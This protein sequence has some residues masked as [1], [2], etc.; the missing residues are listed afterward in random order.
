[1]PTVD[2]DYTLTPRAERVLRA[3]SEARR[4]GH[5]YVGAEHLFWALMGNPDSVPAQVLEKAGVRDSAVQDVE[6]IIG[7]SVPS[8]LVVDLDGN[9]IGHMTVGP[10]GEARIVDDDGREVDLSALSAKVAS[11]SFDKVRTSPQTS[12]PESI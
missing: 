2:I 11:L 6:R 7:N 10:G 5:E 12:T 1:V 9:V 3:A 8:D 4:R